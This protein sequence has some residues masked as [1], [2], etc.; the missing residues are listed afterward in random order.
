MTFFLKIVPF[1]SYMEKY[2]TGRQFTDDN[3]AHA[4]FMLD[5]DVY[6]R[7]ILIRNKR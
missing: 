5:T 6:K 4:H 3:T 7:A 2:G 1:M